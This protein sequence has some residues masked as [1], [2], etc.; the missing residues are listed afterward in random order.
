CLD[1]RRPSRPFLDPPSRHRHLHHCPRRPRL[2]IGAVRHRR[3]QGLLRR[4]HR[5]PALSLRRHRL[6]QGQRVAAAGR[7]KR[8]RAP[9]R[10]CPRERAARRRRPGRD[11]HARLPLLLPLHQRRLA[12]GPD[13]HGL[14]GKVR[15]LLARL[16]HP[17]RPV[18]PR[19]PGALVAEAEL[20]AQAADRVR[21]VQV[22]PHGRLRPPP[23]PRRRPPRRLLV[24]P[25][26]A[27]ARA[28]P[29]AARLDDLRRCLGRR[30][31]P[32]PHGLQ[33][34]PL[35]AR[36]LP[37]LQPDDGQPDH[38]GRHHA[39]PRRPQRRAPEPESHLHRAHDPPRRPRPV[40]GPAPPRHPLHP[41][42][43]HDLWLPPRRPLHGRLRRHAALHLQAQP[44]RPLRQR[45]G[46]RP[47]PH[48]RL[49]PEPALR[50]H[51]HG[52]DLRQ[53]HLPRVRL[54][55]GP[56]EHEVARHERQPVHERP[57]LR[58]RPG[59]HPP[60]RRPLPRLELQR[61]CLHCRPRRTRLLVL[62]PPSRLRRGQVEH[63]EEV[64]F[65]RQEAPRGGTGEGGGGCM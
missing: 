21:P 50:P 23:G 14:R 25:G 29:P 10:P 42:P 9:A 65:Y 5:R 37:L 63:V 13:R 3:Q 7:A 8:R 2:G 15:G 6:L 16:P 19:A 27:V 20:H 39:A 45:Q 41:H 60:L 57:L 58:H 62:F 54:L 56:R 22:P 46:L 49:G 40:P 59:L 30:G 32:R 44:L 17:G 28:R 48:Q 47:G 34:L 33:G 12:L 38:P 36:L 51:R 53:R 52:R 11:Q 18:P 55:Q 35:P 43:A 4:L 31:P 26:Q 61:H 1:R 64:R 24:G